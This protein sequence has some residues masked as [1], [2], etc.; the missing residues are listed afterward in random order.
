MKSYIIFLR[1]NE[2]IVNT[3]IEVSLEREIKFTS[4][5]LITLSAQLSG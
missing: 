1:D 4:Q 5:I 3:L 2:I